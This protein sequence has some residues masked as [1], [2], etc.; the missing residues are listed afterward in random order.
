MTI[1]V[2][3]ISGWIEVDICLTERTDLFYGSHPLQCPA[4]PPADLNVDMFQVHIARLGMLVD[5]VKSGVASLSYVMSW[6]NPA[7]TL[8]SVIIFVILCLRFNA[9]YVGWCVHVCCI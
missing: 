4:R 3:E 9:E 2:G 1:C 5:D 6:K 8:L 7:L